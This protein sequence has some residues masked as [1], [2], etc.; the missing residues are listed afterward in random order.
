[1]RTERRYPALVESVEDIVLLPELFV[2]MGNEEVDTIPV[3]EHIW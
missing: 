3:R 1:M 2:S